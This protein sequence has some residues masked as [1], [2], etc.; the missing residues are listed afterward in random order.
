[1]FKCLKNN[2]WIITYDYDFMKAALNTKSKERETARRVYSIIRQMIRTEMYDMYGEAD[3]TLIY[4]QRQIDP[5]L[6]Y[7][8]VCEIEK[9]K[10]RRE[11]FAKEYK[12]QQEYEARLFEARFNAGLV[13]Y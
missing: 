11:Q 10:Q 3:D 2:D 9:E 4:I 8:R 13:D 1:M 12:E 5:D 6:F 7:R